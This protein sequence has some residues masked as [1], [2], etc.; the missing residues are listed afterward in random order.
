M[1]VQSTAQTFATLAD[2]QPFDTVILAD[3][4]AEGFSEEQIKMLVSNTEQM[5]AGLIMLGG[6]NSFGAGGWTNTPLE[7]AMPVDF[8]I[9]NS[10]VVPVG[11]LAMLMHASEMAEGN[12]WQKKIAQEALRASAAQDYCGVIALGREYPMALDA[13]PAARRR[14]ARNNAREDRQDDAGRHARIRRGHEI[15]PGRIRPACPTPR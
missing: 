3:T 13:R 5:G 14:G 15:G 9:K 1:R 2:L 6:P 4:P 10:K 7:A 11:A 8:Q 12:F